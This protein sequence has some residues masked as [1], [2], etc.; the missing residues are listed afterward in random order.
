MYQVIDKLFP[1]S[2]TY[3]EDLH[4]KLFGRRYTKDDFEQLNAFYA[5]RGLDQNIDLID[6]FDKVE[7]LSMHETQNLVDEVESESSQLVDE[8]F[9]HFQSVFLVDQMAY[10]YLSE[11]VKHALTVYHVVQEKFIDNKLFKA[12]PKLERILSKKKISDSIIDGWYFNNL[13]FAINHSVFEYLGV[14]FDII[15]TTDKAFCVRA[16]NF[17]EHNNGYKLGE[18]I[19]KMAS[20]WTPTRSGNKRWSGTFKETIVEGEKNNPTHSFD[21]ISDK[22]VIYLYAYGVGLS[23]G[24]ETFWFKKDQDGN[25]QKVKTLQKLTR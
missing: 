4:N 6:I 9:V 21:W 13:F 24:S 11:A 15:K 22:E 14:N 5:Y 10:Y 2:L 8:Y 7:T 18:R 20:N 16:I 1:Q 23:G 12:N 3:V 25:W 19:S 17:L